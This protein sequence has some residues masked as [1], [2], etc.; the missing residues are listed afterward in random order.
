[1]SDNSL[2]M[3][4]A[5]FA[6]HKIFGISGRAQSGKST[7]AEY[8]KTEL[9][10]PDFYPEWDE[11]GMCLRIVHFADALK[12]FLRNTMGLSDYQLNN[13][14]GKT[15][16]THLKWED[17]P[18]VVSEKMACNITKHSN[19]K[20]AA[21]VLAE[22]KIKVAEGCMTGREVMEYFG[23]DVIRRMYEDAWVRA[24]LQEIAMTHD[25]TV[26]IIADV[27]SKN[28]IAKIFGAGGFVIRLTRD[29]EHRD[30]QIE[31]QLDQSE[32]NWENFDVIIDNKDMTLEEKNQKGLEAFYELFP[33][34][35]TTV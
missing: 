20:V 4:P 34:M 32:Y 10:L 30:T 29:P 28:E 24:T 17:M 6:K 9:D 12:T 14:E 21:Q 1:M 18:G 2:N 8:I 15:E 22:S 16:L 35:K 25:P 19:P 26:F 33:S 13:D 3:S 27:R 31:R 5:S 11:E 7:L 23:T